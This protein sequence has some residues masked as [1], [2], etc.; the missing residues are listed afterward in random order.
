MCDC[1]DENIAPRTLQLVSAL[2]N[3]TTVT[4][5]KVEMHT[6]LESV[7]CD[8]NSEICCIQPL[9]FPILFVVK[10]RLIIN[11][12]LYTIIVGLTT[13]MHISDLL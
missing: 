13:W 2:A 11:S 3:V 5:E 7:D 9:L 12:G 1:I 10:Q 4:R 6:F 8:K